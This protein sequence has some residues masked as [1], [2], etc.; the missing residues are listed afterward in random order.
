MSGKATTNQRDHL[1][2]EHGIPDPKVP[3]DTKQSTLN[4]YR[5]P[6]IRLDVLR[7]LIVEW[8]V[9][10]RHSFIET[11]S[12]ALFKIFEFLDPRSTNALMVANTTRRDITKYFETAKETIQERLSLARSQIHISYDLWTSPN[13]KAMIAIVAHWTAE[14]Y[15]VKSAL[16]A[17]REVHGE[18]NG[19]NIANVVYPVMKEYNIHS[20]F[21]YFVGDN[22]SNNNT[23]IECLDQ[24]MREDGHEG[25]KPIKRRLRCFAHE[26]Q[27][28]TKGLLFG[29]N[30][31]AL[32]EYPATVGVTEE[33]KR[34]YAKK[35]WRAFGAVGKLHNVVKYIRGSPQR[36]EAYSIVRDELRKEAEQKIRVPVMDNNT[37][38]G[39][40]MDMVEYALKNRV[41][42][43]MYCRG[44]KELEEDRL[45]EQ[46]WVD[47]DAVQCTTINL[48]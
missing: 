19:E 13:H 5:R 44:I 37:R 1:N 10:R 21:G 43:D 46:D 9:E 3:I 16:L 22:A 4:I 7:K 40:V 6:P 2:V 24:L 18:H 25:F 17:I 35:K 31:K 32:E 48:I 28:A 23:S 33:E 41:H 8:I 34:E 15:E 26:M 12:E 20:R 30:V 11:E 36:R 14:D 29:P 47:L 38:W 45:T 39:S 42:L 27:I